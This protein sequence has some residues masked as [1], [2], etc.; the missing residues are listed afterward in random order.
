MQKKVGREEREGRGGGE[1]IFKRTG[2]LWKGGRGITPPKSAVRQLLL[3]K[4]NRSPELRG[5]W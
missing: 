1:R 5:E 4:K 2:K 3:V